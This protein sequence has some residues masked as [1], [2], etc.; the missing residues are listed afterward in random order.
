MAALRLRQSVCIIQYTYI[1]IDD[2]ASYSYCK[3]IN[4]VL[5]QLCGVH[6]TFHSH[7]SM[8]QCNLHSFYANA[9]CNVALHLHYD[10]NDDILFANLHA[11]SVVLY[12]VC[13]ITLSLI[14]IVQQCNLHSLRFQLQLQLQ[15]SITLIFTLQLIDDYCKPINSLCDC[16]CNCNCN[17]QHNEMQTK[18]WCNATMFP[19]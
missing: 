3:S 10:C 11:A 16:S 18:T 8:Q 14:N 2:G 6:S 7:S 17:S 12:D 9:I 4:C 15:C 19:P 1:T 13:Y 5:H